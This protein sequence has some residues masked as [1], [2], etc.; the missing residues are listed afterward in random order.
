MIF[1]DADSAERP[2][3]IQRG[4]CLTVKGEKAKKESWK[5]DRP[6]SNFIYANGFK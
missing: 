2:L 1:L 6:A 5:S 4:L 3:Q